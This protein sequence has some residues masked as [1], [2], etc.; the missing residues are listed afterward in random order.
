[1]AEL[2]IDISQPA[3]EQLAP[4]FTLLAARCDRAPFWAAVTFGT[5]LER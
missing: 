4:V 3:A 2:F 5:A 1:M